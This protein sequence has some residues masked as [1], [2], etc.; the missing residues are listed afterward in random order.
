MN[1]SSETNKY[2]SDFEG[3]SELTL[4]DLLI[5]YRKA[6][7]DVFFENVF[8]CALKFA[9][10]EQNLVPNL[11][12]LLQRLKSQQGFAKDKDLLGDFRL[13]P[14]KLSFER[15]KDAPIGHVYF[16]DA[17]R[18]FKNLLDIHNLKPGFR[19][20]GDFPVDTHVISALWINK[21][22][23]KLDAC[24]DD[25]TAYGSRLRRVRSKELT[26]I[27]KQRVFHLTAV[28][29]FE[30]YYQP[31]QQWRSDGLKK[32]RQELENNHDVVAVSLDLRSFYHQ[33]DP[34]FLIE[35]DFLREL[36]L[37]DDQ[38]LKDSELEFNKEMANFL[39]SW[40]LGA[41][42]FAKELTKREEKVSGGLAIGLTASR[43]IS[44]ILLR[45][46]DRLIHEKVT[47]V[48]YGRYVDDMFLVMRDPGNISSMNDL[49]VFLKERLGENHLSEEGKKGRGL[50][51]ISLGELYQKDSVIQLQAQKQKLFVLR[52]HAGIDLLDTIEKEIHELSSKYRLM[53]SPDRL[54]QTTAAQV[55]SAA[56]SVG[57]GVDSLRRADNLTIRRLSWALQ[58]RHV[59][60]LSHDLPKNAWKSQ[61][62]D[63]YRFAHDHVLRPERLFDHF[64]HLPRLLGFAVELNEWAEAEAVFF[65][66][67][68]SLEQLQKATNKQKI[69]INGSVCVAEDEDTVWDHL[70][71]SFY[72]RFIDAV[73]RYYNPNN[74]IGASQGFIKGKRFWKGYLMIL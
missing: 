48:H 73:I 36:G 61:R 6:K 1:Y 31:Y 12:A 62:A 34:L 15:K 56:E 7:A 50:W 71:K 24:L 19:I 57:E 47:P 59:E 18:A 30:P 58:M 10:Y 38:A 11:K 66:T 69:E 39:D 32:I 55:L 43:I 37:A 5:A 2:L 64:N 52:G 26:G 35:E 65:S 54:E 21:V 16:S 70:R 46:W 44:N 9:E 41:E 42:K 4:S 68:S 25:K 49:M 60:T 22:G 33:I 67:F 17:D 27:Q 28:G 14:K 29:S 72:N 40:S 23:H 13:V 8:P 53:P 3:W 51:N 45:R 20:I 63:F 74:L